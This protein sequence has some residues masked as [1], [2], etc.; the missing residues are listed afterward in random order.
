ML[1]LSGRKVSL[2]S[3]STPS[4]WGRNGTGP[5]N[6]LS[7]YG[8]LME[9]AFLRDLRT[10]NQAITRFVSEMSAIKASS[11]PKWHSIHVDSLTGQLH[12]IEKVLASLP[13][14]GLRDAD[15]DKELRSYIVNLGLL[16]KSIE[17]LAPSLKEEM[18]LLKE[19]L[20]RLSA[21]RYWSESLNDLSK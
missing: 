8:L 5:R 13:P 15:L 3:A 14:A 21:A 9:N 17:E 10:A 20:T 4:H 1:T 18:R 7:C 12:E 11:R 2:R 6:R 19:A 16:K